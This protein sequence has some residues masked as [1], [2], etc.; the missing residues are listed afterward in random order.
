MAAANQPGLDVL[1]SG[2]ASIDTVY[3]ASAPPRAGATALLRG[4]VISPPRCGGCGPGTAM[5]LARAGCRVGLI[6]WL[7]TDPEG[8]TC[9]RDWLDIGIE[10]TGIVISERQASPR[11]FLFY[12]PEGGATCYY[13]PSGSAGLRLT[14]Q[15]HALLSRA[16]ALAITVGPAPL[17]E[18]LLAERRPDQLL[19]W[20]VK[21]DPNAFPAT[22]RALLAREAGVICLNRDELEFVASGLP[23]P[24]LTPQPPSSGST[25]KGRRAPLPSPW[26][27]YPLGGGWG[28]GRPRQGPLLQDETAAALISTI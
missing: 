7:G 21:A 15:A 19:A 22:L 23:R 11:S 12:D 10:D 4:P 5:A 17:T 1:V 18:A 25:G 13:H 14:S 2:Y 28:E 6:T 26:A 24:P 8:Q 9:L 27:G 20:N 16:A 3:Q